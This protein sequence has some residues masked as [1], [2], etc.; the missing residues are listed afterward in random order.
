V[1]FFHVNIA[2]GKLESKDRI[3]LGGFFG[4]ETC[5]YSRLVEK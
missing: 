4:T 3:F 2:V 1:E 5:A